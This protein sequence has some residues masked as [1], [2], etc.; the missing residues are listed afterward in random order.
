MPKI[1]K[2]AIHSD[3]APKALGPYSQAIKAGNTVYISGQI[4]LSPQTNQIVADDLGAQTQQ[5]LDNLAAIA[6]ASGGHIDNCVKL[7]VYLT[8]LQAFDAVNACM[9]SFF[10][11]PYPARACVEV[12]ALPRQAL[13]EIDAILQL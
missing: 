12:N 13:I 10:N 8:D 6:K 3:Q 5:V 9:Q 2:T 1:E 11:A 4:A 7:T